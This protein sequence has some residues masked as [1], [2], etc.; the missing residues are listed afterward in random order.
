MEQWNAVYAAA[1]LPADARPAGWDFVFLAGKVLGAFGPELFFHLTAEDQPMRL[2]I[3]NESAT[4][5][6]R[7]NLRM[8]SHAPGLSLQMIARLNLE[9]PA[10]AYPLAAANVE[11][12]AQDANSPRLDLPASLDG[13][14]CLGFD[15]LQR[16]HLINAQASAVVLGEQH[17]PPVNDP[18]APIERRWIAM[19][20]AGAASQRQSV[21]NTIA[22][23][24]AALDRNGFATGARCWT[25]SPVRHLQR[26]RMVST[27]FWRY[28]ST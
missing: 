2:A 10:I 21:T 4:L 3:E 17:L 25:P 16:K 18:L 13:R 22:T 9:Q 24:T 27:H 28:G 19:L 26:G 15:E 5:Y 12:G 1:S 11:Q 23:E 20:L 14:I 8:L 6:F 7:E